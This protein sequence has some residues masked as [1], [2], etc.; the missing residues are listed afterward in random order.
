[1][2]EARDNGNPQKSSDV[3][4]GID[5]TQTVNAYPQWER[6][7]SASPIKLSENVPVNYIVKRLKAISS[8][9]DTTVSF[10]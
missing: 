6:D 1:M 2:I 9:P 3:N 7:Y 5:I 8:V 10:T 4:V